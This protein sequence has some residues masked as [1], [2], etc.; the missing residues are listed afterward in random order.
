LIEFTPEAERQ[1]DELRSFYIRKLRSDALRN[2]LASL[3]AA[4]DQIERHP[5]EGKSAPRPYPDLII[6]G[7]VW[8][9]SGRYW[10]AYSTTK[11]PVIVGVFFETSD[12]P[13]LV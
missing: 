1:V 10:V 7:R 3:R 12:I 5:N 6:P 13:S 2:F 4:V 8:V 9:K 11:P